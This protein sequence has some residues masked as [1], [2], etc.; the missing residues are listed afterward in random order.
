MTLSQ[1]G[2]LSN[3]EGYFAELVGF[4]N[5]SRFEEAL[6]DPDSSSTSLGMA[7]AELEAARARERAALGV[8]ES[9]VRSREGV[10]DQLARRIQ[11]ELAAIGVA[12]RGR[13]YWEECDESEEEDAMRSE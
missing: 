6:R 4:E 1:A 3:R 5:L 8:V 12:T 11:D 13:G 7:L 10:F 2:G 9:L